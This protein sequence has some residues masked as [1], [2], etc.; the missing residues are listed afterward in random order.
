[1]ISNRLALLGLFALT[2]DPVLGQIA[3]TG[4]RAFFRGENNPLD[5]IGGN[6]GVLN[7]GFAYVPDRNSTGYAFGLNGPSSEIRVFSPGNITLDFRRFTIA[8]WVKIDPGSE[9]VTVVRKV[10]AAYDQMNYFFFAKTTYVELAF[11]MGGNI[12]EARSTQPCVP[13]QWC[14]IA[15]SYDGATMRLYVNGMPSSAIV[16]TG[17]VLAG[18]VNQPDNFGP[19]TGQPTSLGWGWGALDEVQ[20]Y[21]RALSDT[22]ILGLMTLVEPLPG[23]GT[24]GIQGIQ[25]IPGPTGA[26]GPQ[27]IPGTPGATGATGAVGPVGPIGPIGATGAV[28]ATG[29]PGATG[30]TGATGAMGPIGPTGPAGATGATGAPGLQGIPG[31]PGAVGATG[32]AGP[33][34]ATGP[35]GLPGLQGLPGVA[36]PIGPPGP[37]G[38]AGPPGPMGVSG[39]NGTNGA[40]GLSGFQRVS[41]SCGA[42]TIAKGA[43]IPA[44]NAPCPTGKMALGGGVQSTPSDTLTTVVSWPSQDNSW[45]TIVRNDDTKSATYTLTSWA[46]CASVAP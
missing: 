20:I 15:S 36:G 14:F 17:G 16:Y 13:G 34:G 39:L 31:T 42:V 29:A 41:T 32:P 2:L 11:I 25:G 6:V 3:P 10:N 22:E 1:M 40:P 28:G 5:Q 8:A 4:R 38:V 24:P 9:G 43:T 33:I 12:I 46:V 21:D 35:Q 18:T 27:G 44:C 45:S 30:A 7:P 19:L 23:P 37:Q 26:T